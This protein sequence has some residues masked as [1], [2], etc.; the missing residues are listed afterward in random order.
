VTPDGYLTNCWEVTSIKHPNAGVFIVGRILD[1]GRH[2]LYQEKLDY[3]RRFSV[4]HLKQCSDCF[5]KWHCSGD[6][7]LRAFP[8]TFDGFRGKRCASTR[9]LMARKLIGN[10]ENILTDQ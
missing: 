10:I 4:N 7:A 9:F 8:E 5:A 3:L 1:D 2:E 6:C